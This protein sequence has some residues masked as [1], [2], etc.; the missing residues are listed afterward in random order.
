MISIISILSKN[1][2]PT[3]KQEVTEFTLDAFGDILACV[4]TELSG[5]GQLIFQSFFK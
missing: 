5:Q 4:S 1:N 2:V 3:K